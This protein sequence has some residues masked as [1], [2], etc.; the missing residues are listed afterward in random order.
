MAQDASNFRA[1]GAKWLQENQAKP[2]DPKGGV[3][4]EQGATTAGTMLGTVVGAYFGNPV[5]GAAAGRSAGSLVGGVVDPDDPNMEPSDALMRAA[6]AA[7]TS[8]IQLK[9]DGPADEAASVDDATAATNVATGSDFAT[10]S[11]ARIR[12]MY[13]NK[14]SRTGGY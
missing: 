14:K 13:Q 8:A 12:D 3:T 10:K 6:P 9:G 1:L 5:A 2:A 4:F 11:A 7:L